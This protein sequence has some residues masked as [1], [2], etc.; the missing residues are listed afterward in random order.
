MNRR[1]AILAMLGAVAIYGATTG[2][3]DVL[4][5]RL[6]RGFP[7]A[8][9]LVEAAARAGERGEVVATWLGRTSPRP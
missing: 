9:A 2:P 7:R 4:M 8:V 3:S 1:L 5:P 6:E